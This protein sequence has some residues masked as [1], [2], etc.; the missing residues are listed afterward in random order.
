MSDL[1][2]RL[3][4]NNLIYNVTNADA[5][6]TVCEIV[7]DW[8]MEEAAELKVEYARD[9]A[10]ADGG[11]KHYRITLTDQTALLQRLAQDIRKTVAL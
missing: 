8:L 7:A 4:R 11:D 2:D 9:R 10:R 6:D 1:R 5:T 3:N